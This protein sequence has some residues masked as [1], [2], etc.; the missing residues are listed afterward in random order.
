MNEL[1]Q[2][3]VAILVLAVVVCACACV[4][5]AR[6][7]KVCRCLDDLRHRLPEDD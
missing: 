2:I 6:L 7:L 1:D 5:D 3:L 4:L